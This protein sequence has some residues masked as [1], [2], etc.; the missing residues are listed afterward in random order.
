MFYYIILLKL[1]PADLCYRAVCLAVTDG[2]YWL[3]KA[4]LANTITGMSYNSNA[5]IIMLI[6]SEQ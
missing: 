4:C 2:C 5:F 6:A 3:Q 1:L